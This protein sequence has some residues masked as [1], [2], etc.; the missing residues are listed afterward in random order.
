ML[1]P[2]ELESKSIKPFQGTISLCLHKFETAF[3]LGQQFPGWDS[4]TCP[5]TQKA[6]VRVFAPASLVIMKQE[7]PK[8]PALGGGFKDSISVLKPSEK[9]RKIERARSVSTYGCKKIV[10]KHLLI[11]LK[12]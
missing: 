11:Y 3:L 8:C 2:F 4:A 10:L 9:S 7:L 12:E 6:G 1:V 5:H